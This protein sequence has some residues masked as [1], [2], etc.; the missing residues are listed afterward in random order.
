M[1]SIESLGLGSGVL[2]TDLVEQIISAEK[3]VTELRLD[4][5]QELIE[6][7]ITAYG[8][9]QSLMSTMQSAVNKLASPSTSGATKATSSDEDIL[10]VSSSITADPGTYTVEVLNTAKSHSLATAAY[11]SFD[12]IVGTGTLTFSFGTS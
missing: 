10:T 1:A 6:A 9:I 3:E 12:E 5:R 4:N 11:E 2:T 8:E 7:K